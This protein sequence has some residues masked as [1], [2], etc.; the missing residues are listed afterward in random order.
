MDTISR[1]V[2]LPVHFSYKVLL[3][4]LPPSVLFSPFLSTTLLTIG[5]L[6][7]SPNTVLTC[8]KNTKCGEGNGSVL[9]THEDIVRHSRATDRENG[10]GRNKTP[11]GSEIKK[12]RQILPISKFCLYRLPDHKRANLISTTKGDC[13]T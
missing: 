3:L 8:L 1:E 6:F 5:I 9:Q 11:P 13:S 4:K 2:S 7:C 10:D 12:L